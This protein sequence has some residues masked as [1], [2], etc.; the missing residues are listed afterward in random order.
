MRAVK[1]KKIRKEVYGDLAYRERNYYKT[2]NGM[3][4]S[5]DK[6]REYQAKKK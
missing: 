1:A 2:N 5:D 4:V 6:R 3:I